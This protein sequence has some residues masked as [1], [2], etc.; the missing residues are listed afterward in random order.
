M[1]QL[2]QLVRA[3]FVMS[4]FLKLI[5]LWW[6]KDE[7]KF[8]TRHNQSTTRESAERILGIYSP[9]YIFTSEQCTEKRLKFAAKIVGSIFYNCNIMAEGFRFIYLA[10][11]FS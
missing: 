10:F 2:L 9:K 11:G 8:I 1:R 6:T 3:T 5:L 4:N 7:D